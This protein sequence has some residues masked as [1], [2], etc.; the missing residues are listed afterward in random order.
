ML[1]PV[2]LVLSSAEAGIWFG[3]ELGKYS[4]ELN[5]QGIYNPLTDLATPEILAYEHSAFGSTRII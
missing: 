1:P 4:A 2:R 5:A 3:T